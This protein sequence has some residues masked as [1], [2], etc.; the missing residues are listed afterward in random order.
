MF[1]ERITVIILEILNTSI[2]FVQLLSVNQPWVPKSWSFP[3]AYLACVYYKMIESPIILAGISILC[4]S[5]ASFL[6]WVATNLMKRAY[7]AHHSFDDHT[8]IIA[9]LEGFLS[10]ITAFCFL[11]FAVTACSMKIYQNGTVLSISTG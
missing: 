11:L 1:L 7:S 4:S 6:I 3:L 2:F 9:I 8:M 5:L 10:I